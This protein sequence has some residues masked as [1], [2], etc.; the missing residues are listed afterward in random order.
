M[1][2]F[3]LSGLVAVLCAVSVNA[4]AGDNAY[5]NTAEYKAIDAKARASLQECLKNENNMTR[6]C[7]EQTKDMMKSAKKQV[8]KDY[9]M[10][11]KRQQGPVCTALPASL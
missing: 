8:K 1:K 11:Q 6:D 3:M 2:K 10:R 4:L 9:K 7:M 5:K